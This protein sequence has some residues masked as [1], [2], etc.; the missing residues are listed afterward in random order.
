MIINFFQYAVT[1]A[2]NL[3][4]IEKNRQ[5]ISKIKPF[6][7]QYWKDI[8]FPPTSKYWRK[9]ELNNKVAL[10]ILYMPH[11]IKKNTTWL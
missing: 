5:R 9:F 11:N 8:Y 6:I 3:D 10:K 2:L 1:L 7:N 4:N